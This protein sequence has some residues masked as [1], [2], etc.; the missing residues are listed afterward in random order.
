MNTEDLKKEAAKK[1]ITLISDKTIVGLGA[2]S[3]IG[4]V[5][6][7]LKAQIEN[8]LRIQLVTSSFSTRQFLLKSGF[9][10]QPIAAFKSIDIYFDGCDQLDSELNALKSGGGIHTQEKLL[11]SMANEF[12][13]IGDESKLVQNFDNRF[14]VVIELLPQAVCYVPGCIQNFF[15][16]SKIAYRIS[17]KKDGYVITEN[18]NYLLD[19]WLGEWPDLSIINPLLKS[20]TGVVETSLFYKLANKAIIAGKEGIKVLERMR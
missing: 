13:L 17:E 5:F 15:P 10:V 2:G 11:A 4:Y 3:T 19:V 8:G 12:I 16:D 1:A 7:F 20:I 9:M 6:Q 14:P 18:G